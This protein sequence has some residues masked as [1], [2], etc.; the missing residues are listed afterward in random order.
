MWANVWAHYWSKV[1]GICYQRVTCICLGILSCICLRALLF[2]NLLGRVGLLGKGA[3]SLVATAGYDVSS[4]S[5]LV[6]L[7]DIRT[8]MDTSPSL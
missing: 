5:S 4:S 8:F 6:A 2:S 1:N 7:E 3:L